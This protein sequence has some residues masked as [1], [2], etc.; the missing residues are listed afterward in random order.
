M[1]QTGRSEFMYASRERSHWFPKVVRDMYELVSD[2]FVT[3]SVIIARILFACWRPAW[4]HFFQ[5]VPIGP[6]PNAAS[7]YLPDSTPG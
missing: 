6:N 2:A 1:G 4:V 3:L 7:D 5:S